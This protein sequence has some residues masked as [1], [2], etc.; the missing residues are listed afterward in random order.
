MDWQQ[1]QRALTSELT[2]LYDHREAALIA[3]WVME[4]LTGKKKLDRLVLKTQQ[5]TQKELDTYEEY[6]AGLLEHRP[7][8]YVLHESWFGGMKF[9][10]DES[11]LIPR[12]ETEEL[13]EWV[14][15]TATESERAGRR[16]KEV[17]EAG[18]AGTK[19]SED[20]PGGQGAGRILDVGTGSGCIAIT[21]SKKLPGAEVHACDVS[22]DALAVA[23]R[24][25][26]ALG[27]SVHFHA[28]N[29]LEAKAW[30]QL[31]EIHYLVSNPPYIPLREKAVMAA[32]VTGFE[33][34]LALFV[35][36][37]TPLL[38]YTKLAEFGRQKLAA[39]G[40]VFAEIH[41]DLGPQTAAVFRQAG[42]AEVVL[43]RDLQGKERM[44]KATR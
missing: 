22:G 39:G 13:V 14:V 12:P 15:E 10:V 2:P 7:V 19:R 3:D 8:Q 26:V 5:F 40:A 38:F 18:G 37:E 11:V 6:K 21:L 17:S 32:H 36:D 27:A 33:P 30:A 4:S 35:P 29:F 31:P 25:A 16:G 42:F 9:Y 24:N 43:R 41:E 1:A 20:T 23:E 28:L 44:I 34:A